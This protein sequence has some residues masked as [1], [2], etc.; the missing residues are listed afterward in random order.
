MKTQGA[1]W[2][3]ELS[4]YIQSKPTLI[5]NGFKEAGIIDALQL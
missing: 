4:H 1:K 2:I 3:M 5:I